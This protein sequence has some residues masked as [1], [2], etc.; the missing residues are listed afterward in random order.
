MKYFVV[1]IFDS[2]VKAY[3]QPGYAPSEEAAIRS[4]KNVFKQEG[5]NPLKQNPE[6]HA[7]FHLGY[8][9]DNTGSID[10][11]RPNQLVRGVDCLSEGV[12]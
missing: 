10:S 6:D 9:D 12:K 3:M 8:F 7:L 11:I 1:A 4:F 2:A 5:P